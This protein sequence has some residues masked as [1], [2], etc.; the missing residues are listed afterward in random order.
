M[1]FASDDNLHAKLWPAVSGVNTFLTATDLKRDLMRRIQLRKD[2]LTFRNGYPIP[3]D[4]SVIS[5][6]MDWA[7]RPGWGERIDRDKGDD[8]DLPAEHRDRIRAAFK[9]FDSMPDE[10][11]LL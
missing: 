6:A 11:N 3:L 1:V 4:G 9:K 10:A 5:A 8:D 7:F 2:G